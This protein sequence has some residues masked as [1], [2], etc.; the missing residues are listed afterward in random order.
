MGHRSEAGVA[1][2]RVLE[3]V[4]SV[5]TAGFAIFRQGGYGSFLGRSVA[6]KEE[7]KRAVRDV[8]DSG[9][10]FLKVVN[11]GIVSADRSRPVSEGGFSPGELKIISAEARERDL[12]IACH[13]NSD[14]AIKEAVAAGVSSIEH[15]FFIS[16]ETLHMMSESGV[17]WTP[18]AIAL[19]SLG[20]FLPAEEKKYIE[21][22]VDGHLA[23]ISY[24]ASI[25]V[26]LRVGTDSGS[27]TVA[28]GA[29]FFEELRLFQ[30]AGLSLDQILSA[31]CVDEEEMDKGRSIFVARD[32][33]TT[34]KI[35][36]INKKGENIEPI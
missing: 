12:E 6:G 19:L 7:I 25:G 17:S 36:V 4:I 35:E 1:A 18:T 16:R 11:S 5:R 21:E 15:G 32:F 20:T 34:G 30:R 8:A 29:S 10:D 14:A 22:V 24:A 23:S 9:A 3:N 31:A 13:A 26:T 2:R 27:K 33:I 28:H